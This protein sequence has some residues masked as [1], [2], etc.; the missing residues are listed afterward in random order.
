[1]ASRD[2]A[3]VRRTRGDQDRSPGMRNT[4]RRDAAASL[5]EPQAEPCVLRSSSNNS[6]EEY[7]TR[8]SVLD[9]TMTM[10]YR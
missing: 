8:R 6:Q 7:I 10:C 1:M 2:R 4:D 9:R 3:P 5:G